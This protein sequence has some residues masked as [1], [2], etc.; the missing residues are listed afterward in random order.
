MFLVEANDEIRRRLAYLRF[1]N[2]LVGLLTFLNLLN[3]LI[4]YDS[5]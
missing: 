5:N 2:C 1:L 4:V 3:C